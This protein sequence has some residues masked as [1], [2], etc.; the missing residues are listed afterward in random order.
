MAPYKLYWR[1]GS[2][3]LVAD[4]ALAMVGVSYE[5]IEVAAE[6][7]A[8]LTPQFLAVNPLAQIPVVVMP[9][10]TILTETAAI[11]ITLDELHP[12]AMLLP[13]RGTKDRIAALRWL[14]IMATGVYPAAIRYYYSSR[15]TTD[16]AETAIA[17]V[18]AAAAADLD[19]IFGV[20]LP[21][22][23]GPFIL[24]KTMT[25]VDVYLAMLGDWHPAVTS[26][27]EFR[28]LREA[29]LAHPGISAAWDR[30]GYPR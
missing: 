9:D 2:G 23:E 25:I 6:R 3:S 15:Y 16:P 12:Q 20:I 30:H 7:E 27:P 22:I 28:T 18:Q 24:G 17:A 1:A 21:A 11:Q 10:G 26:T 4:A 8:L 29:V 5:T 13:P 14:M 19:R